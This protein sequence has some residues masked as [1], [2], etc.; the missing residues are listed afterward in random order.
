MDRHSFLKSFITEH[1][2]N[3]DIVQGWNAAAADYGYEECFYTGDID[4]LFCGLR[5][6]EVLARI[7]TEFNVNDSY[8][9]FNGYSQAVSFNSWE[10][11][12]SP[13]DIDVLVSY[14]LDN[15]TTLAETLDD[16][17]AD[18]LTE[19]EESLGLDEDTLS[20]FDEAVSALANNTLDELGQSD[21]EDE[22]DEAETFYRVQVCQNDG[23]EFGNPEDFPTYDM[24][25]KY[26]A[27]HGDRL[28][29]N[30][31]FEV[32]LMSNDDGDINFETCVLTRFKG[33]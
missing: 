24:A 29:D 22:E 13:V 15:E 11:S 2:D 14:L 33:E 6:S 28:D 32:Y 19:L 21:D 17:Q 20:D 25:V 30:T 26:I 1:L 27:T 8:F 23:G 5:P 9:S 3:F 7:S 12:E 10:D 4:D 31:H 18:L 16:Y